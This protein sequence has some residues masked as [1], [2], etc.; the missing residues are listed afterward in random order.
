MKAIWRLLCCRRRIISSQDNISVQCGLSGL[1]KRDEGCIGNGIFRTVN[2]LGHD[3]IHLAFSRNF[4]T[5]IN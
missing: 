1:E 5:I 4:L 3:I 2:I